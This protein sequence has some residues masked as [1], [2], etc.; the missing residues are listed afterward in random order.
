[1]KKTAFIL[2]IFICS[3]MNAHSQ[4]LAERLGF[5]RNDRIL[6]INNDDAGMCH[7]ANKATIE[8]M[9]NGVISSATIMTPCPWYNEIASYAAAN[10]SKGFGVHLTLTSEWKHYRWGTVAPR[11]KVPGLY[12]EQGYMWKGIR[13][14]YS[15]SNPEEALIEGRAQLKRALNSGIPVTHIDSHMG[16]YQYSP[17]YMDVY[18]QLAKEFNLPLRMPSQA[19]L[20]NLGAPDYREVCRREGILHPDYFIHEELEGYTTENIAE[21]WINYIKNLKPGVT[22]IYVHASAEGEEIRT[23]THSAAKR[24]RELEFFTSNELKELIEKE[25]IV[26]INYRPLLELQR[27]ETEHQ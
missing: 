22:E 15:S 13:E 16:T 26:V 19:T 3:C 27:K 10:P 9:E 17:D 12:D 18:I 8:G 25:G 5:T 11:D 7:A 23:I 6:I 2:M 4:T 14:V 20:E 24:I 21:F 1:M